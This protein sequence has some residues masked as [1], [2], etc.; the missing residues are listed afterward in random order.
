MTAPFAPPPSTPQITIVI[1]IIAFA[2]AMPFAR[3]PDWIGWIAF[4][5][6]TASAVALWSLLIWGIGRAIVEWWRKRR[7]AG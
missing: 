4:L 7:D 1:A 5:T 3:H 6:I 2:I